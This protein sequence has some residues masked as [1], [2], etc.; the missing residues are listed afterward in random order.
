MWID[1]WLGLRKRRLQWYDGVHELQG[2]CGDTQ[3]LIWFWV[4]WLVAI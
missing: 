1:V 4:S 2:V 3:T